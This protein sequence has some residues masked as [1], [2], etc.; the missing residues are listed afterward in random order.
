MTHPATVVDCL[1]APNGYQV[2]DGGRPSG[3]RAGSDDLGEA[4]RCY[5]TAVLAAKEASD[6]AQKAEAPSTG[7]TSTPSSQPTPT[8]RQRSPQSVRLPMRR[9]SPQSSPGPR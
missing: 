3:G 1:Q 9:V 8:G 4:A 5:A 2:P 6:A 7:Q